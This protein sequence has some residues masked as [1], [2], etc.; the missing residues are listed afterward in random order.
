M[1][2]DV[3]TR[4]NFPALEEGVLADWKRDDIFKKSV[5][6]REGQPRWVFYEGPPTANG[7][8]GIHHVLARVFKDL[9]PR[10][11]TMRGYY[12][13][14]IGGWDTH[15][16][17]VEVQVEKQLG[18]NGKKDIEAYGIAKFNA[19]CRQSVF[20]YVQDWERLTERHAY[21]VDLDNAYR[22]YNNSYIES[23]WWALKQFWDR[24]LLFQDYK[25]TMHCPRC[26]TSLADAEVALG[27]KDN[28]DD[29]FVV[30]RM[31]LVE[32]QTLPFRDGLSVG[33]NDVPTSF[34]IMTTTPWT[35]P[36]NAAVALKDSA[37]YILA[38][39][40]VGDTE[41]VERLIVA[42]QLADA[43]FGEGTYSVLGVATGADLVGLR[44]M[45]LYNGVGQAGKAVDL[46][47][48]YQAITDE[49]VTVGADLPGDAAK[50]VKEKEE[51]TG[52]V[53][54]AP[55]YGDLDVGKRHD[56]P[57]LFSVDLSG[58]VI[59]AFP[60]FK[61]KFFKKADPDITADLKER[62]LIF[63][64][65]RVRHY[66]P[67]CWRCDTPLLFYAKTS[68]YIR[69]TSAK[70]EL[71]ANNNKI[72]WVPDTIRTG[73]FGNW[74]ENNVDWALSRE[75]Y[76]GTP[77]PIWVCAA[78][79]K[80][81]AVGS[82]ADLS[83]KAG[84][85]LSTFDLHRPF[86]DDI[87][88]P[89]DACD[90]TMTRVPE[91]CD[92]WFDSGAMPYAQ[93]HYPF[94]NKELFETGA[95]PAD[96]ICEAI[97]QTRGWF[98]SLH[99]EGTLLRQ[100]PAFKNVIVLGHILDEKGFKMSKSRGN[101]VDPWDVINAHGADALRW[102]LYT[103]SPP[104]QPRRFS[105]ALVGDAV[106]QFMLTLWN[107]Y[108]FF[109]TYAN[110][111]G[112][113]LDLANAPD[114][115]VDERALIDR[116][117]VS[118]QNATIR[119]VTDGLERYDVSAA[120]KALAEFVDNLSNWYV[121]RNRRRFWS[122]VEGAGADVANDAIDYEQEMSDEYAEEGGGMSPMERNR[123][124]MAAYQTLHGALVT[125]SKLLAPFIPF[126]AEAMY[127]NLVLS[128]HP[129]APESVHMAD[130]PTFDPALIDEGLLRDT[131]TVIR[132]VSLGRAARNANKLKVRQPLAEVVVKAPT[133]A[134]EAALERFKQQV[135]EELN[136][137]S[138][139]LAA[140]STE[141]VNYG[142]K[143]NFKTL[144]P[145]YK[146]LLGGIGAALA[147]ADA[148]DTAAKVQAGQPFTL[149]VNGQS[150]ELLPED[151]LIES[152]MQAGYA[153]AEEGG[154]I[155]ALNTDVT[156]ELRR[157]G[158]VRDLVRLIQDTRKQAGFNIAD[159]ISITYAAEGAGADEVR[160]AFTHGGDYLRSETLATQ[161][162]EGD[163][164]ATAFAPDPLTLD[165][166]ATLKLGLV[167]N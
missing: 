17:P 135:Q 20:E 73:R 115:P 152:R 160:D 149:E 99:A 45:P 19:L 42:G 55:A 156:P 97:D 36:A 118:L 39:R 137:E 7:K 134:A 57:T 1:F 165:N 114:I 92:A 128:L 54:I 25:V 11:K 129:D 85:D 162:T 131:G 6:A 150:V 60:Q 108:S 52:I 116:W 82:V 163:A 38:E 80:Q 34:L 102:Y 63:K 15:G 43:L 138:V 14:R 33:A 83:A 153:I 117:L 8:P 123:D 51:N 50:S 77:L 127:R 94:E 10:Y 113:K 21:W 119:D 88:W 40:H 124:K 41:E 104:D 56:L 154:Y 4:V 49:I 69:T 145:K 96:Y 75:R 68:W 93:L 2:K 157:K 98:Y 111:D 86:V 24:K 125:L 106:R 46:T 5:A 79:G 35:L 122:K 84:R 26:N 140:Q 65:G 30:V 110:L 130:W 47:N 29:P 139:R 89:C 78:C 164:P 37:E 112:D 91:V 87:T 58:N 95:F 120:T 103:A 167:R 71:I 136:V 133:R 48:A 151:V 59:E 148:N 16:L 121:R 144:G 72:N 76:W 61:A 70:D 13:P 158:L 147:K 90:G 146:A 32:G 141:V 101:I 74:L 22:T 27:A 109:V 142:V 100:S 81:E 31:R 66:Y 12:V 132:V 64:N 105:S 67:F 159:T 3:N 166:G 53:H 18:F 44:Y 161:L 28:V 23:E 9:F 155:V 62:G 143:P 107:T 126:T